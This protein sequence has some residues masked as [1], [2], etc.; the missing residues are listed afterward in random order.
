MVATALPSRACMLSVNKL[1]SFL[2][3]LYPAGHDIFIRR[4]VVLRLICLCC[5]SSIKYIIV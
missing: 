2:D 4:G 3:S 1:S 5:M